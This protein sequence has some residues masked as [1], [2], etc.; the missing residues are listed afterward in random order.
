MSI[1]PSEQASLGVSDRVLRSVKPEF[2]KSPKDAE[3]RRRKLERIIRQLK[4]VNKLPEVGV[5]PNFGLIPGLKYPVPVQIR[6]IMQ[7][8]KNLDKK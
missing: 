2:A 8:L 3:A 1:D 4:V 5:L 6:L 7:L